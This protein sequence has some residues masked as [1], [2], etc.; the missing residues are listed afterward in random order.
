M[1]LTAGLDELSTDILIKKYK[2]IFVEYA[3]LRK[4]SDAGTNSV[5]ENI[6]ELCGHMNIHQAVSYN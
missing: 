3:L 5:S 1:K 4:M 2:I 6:Q